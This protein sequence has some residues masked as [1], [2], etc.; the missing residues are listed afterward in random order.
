LNSG[1]LIGFNFF[2]RRT[3]MNAWRRRD[4]QKV[5]RQ[6]EGGGATCAADSPRGYQVLVAE[7]H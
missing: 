6:P 3:A 7:Q 5:A 2:L 1:L 4:A